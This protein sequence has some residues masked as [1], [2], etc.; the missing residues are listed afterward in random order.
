LSKRAATPRRH[1]PDLRRRAVD[2]IPSGRVVRSVRHIGNRRHAPSVTCSPALCS[3]LATQQ[4]PHFGSDL[5]DY[6]VV[7]LGPGD[8]GLATSARQPRH[9]LLGETSGSDGGGAEAQPGRIDRLARVGRHRV[10]TL[11]T[12][13]LMRSTVRCAGRVTG[14]RAAGVVRPSRPD[15]L[16]SVK[17]ALGAS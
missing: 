17:R 6:L 13:M 7:F 12:W 5:A 11:A 9:A 1:R 2:L 15:R 10:R 16:L 3:R 14:Q 8:H 4:L